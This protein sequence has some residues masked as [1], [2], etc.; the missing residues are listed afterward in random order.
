[1]SISIDKI[2]LKKEELTK[3]FKDLTDKLKEIEAQK[4]Q[5]TNQAL[6]VNGAIQACQQLI[7]ENKESE[8][9]GNEKDS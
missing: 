5:V 3:D 9:D 2:E 1:M 4:T 7:D 8:N 6:A